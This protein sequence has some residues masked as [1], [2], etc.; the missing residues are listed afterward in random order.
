MK[1]MPVIL[2]E[3]PVALSVAGSDCSCGAGAQADL[4][5]FSAHGVYGLT[6]LTC[7]V[8][9]VPGR[10]TRIEM[11][12]ADMMAA[13]LSLLLHSFPVRAMKTGMVPTADH[14]NA[15]CAVLDS[16]PEEGRPALVVDP[17]MVATCGDRLV[18][19]PA[20][21]ALRENLFRRA[22]LLTPNMGETSVLL[23]REIT[24]EG[25]LGDA[26]RALADTFGIAVL[27]KGGHLDGEMAVDHLIAADGQAHQFRSA[28]IPDRDTHGTGCT[29]SSA[30]VARLALGQPLVEA[31][32]SAKNYVHQAIEHVLRWDGP[33]D[34]LNHFAQPT[35]ES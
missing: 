8:A 31:V 18:D 12:A 9:E 30:I 10:V 15:L 14:V 16:V 4:K 1:K 21:E 20:I 5:T 2:N 3:M 7:V 19:E 22:V 34:A 33:I 23:G 13:Q 11:I 35:T 32:R 27:V 26:A 25:Q 29:L 24:E 28:F 17:V 6:A